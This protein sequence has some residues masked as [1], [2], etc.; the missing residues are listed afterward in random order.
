MS[1]QAPWL[2][3]PLAEAIEQS[4][5]CKMQLCEAQVQLT[6]ARSAATGCCWGRAKGGPTPWERTSV[7]RDSGSFVRKAPPQY[8]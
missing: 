6:Q 3:S 7:P 1:G 8:S 4:I 5:K 2:R